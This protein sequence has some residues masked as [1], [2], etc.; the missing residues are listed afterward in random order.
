MKEIV[1]P[2]CGCSKYNFFLRTYDRYRCGD[3]DDFILVKCQSCG[4][5]FLNPQPEESELKKYYPAT[6]WHESKNRFEE[7]F[8]NFLC[9][10]RFKRIAH[11]KSAG[12]ILDVG[13]GTGKFLSYFK[14]KGWE[15]HGQEISQFACLKAK[16]IIE[17]ICCQPLGQCSFA[18]HTF[19]V[20][21][22]NNVFHQMLEPCRELKEIKRVLKKD[23][24]LCLNVP[25]VESW[26]FKLTKEHWFCVDSPRHLYF[27]S[28]KTI[29]LFLTQNGFQILE[30]FHSFFD[31]PSDLF[32]SWQMKFF[33]EG[34]KTFKSLVAAPFFLFFSLLIRIFPQGRSTLV[35]LAAPKL[36]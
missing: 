19:D 2:I 22:L 18:A 29:R 35:I 25:D 14:N 6:Y 1:C 36:E 26:Q 15:V 34:E 5:V 12:H 27:Y 10:L 9:R 8:I 33:S 30:M 11:Y 24:V 16:K 32:R 28:S 21:I 7:R 31:L 4:F 17:N 13:C 23:G 20:V 3:E